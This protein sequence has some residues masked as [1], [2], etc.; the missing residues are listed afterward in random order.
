MTV[1]RFTNASGAWYLLGLF[2]EL[3]EDKSTALYTLKDRDHLGLPSLYRL[4]M[5]ANDPL[6]FVFANTFLDNYSH[7]VRLTE[8]TW[9]KEYIARWR[10]ELELKLRSEALNRLKSDAASQS[11]SAQVS[12]RFLLDRGWI[13]GDKPRR[14]R[15]TK[16]QVKAEAK[17][18]A[19]ASQQ[20]DADLARISPKLQ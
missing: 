18:Q 7:W 13:I 8:C 10:T 16:D 3:A 11:K 12:N 14:G 1:S 15:P 5:E 2:W 4:Y 9:F 19:E 20:Q 17:R 6:E